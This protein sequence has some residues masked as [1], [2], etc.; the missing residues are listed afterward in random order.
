MIYT[1]DACRL[2]VYTGRDGDYDSIAVL[3]ARASLKS[4]KGKPIP[5]DVEDAWN[6]YINVLEQNWGWLPR[7]D[8]TSALGR[9]Y[10]QFWN[11][12]R[13]CKK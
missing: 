4:D 10:Y 3:N 11:A 1:A 7:D 6:T 2:V 13:K 8:P 12:Y 9:A 5:Q